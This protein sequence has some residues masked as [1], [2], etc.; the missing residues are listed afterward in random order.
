MDS[1]WERRGVLW[2][3]LLILAGA[4][5][6]LNNIGRLEWSLWE[7]LFRL[8]PAILLAAGTAGRH[9]GWPDHHHGGR[10]VIRMETDGTGKVEQP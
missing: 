7:L 2:P 10:R 6:L 5:L 3:V 1:R 8:W 4:I 9:G